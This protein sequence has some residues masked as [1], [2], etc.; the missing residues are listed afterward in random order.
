MAH[1][2][3]KKKGHNIFEMYFKVKV[4]PNSKKEI[5]EKIDDETYRIAVKEKAENNLA[6]RA[7]CNLLAER[8]DINRGDIQIITGHHSQNKIMFIKNL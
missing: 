3:P 8:L 2:N 1:L 7:V 5:F 4:K 6:N